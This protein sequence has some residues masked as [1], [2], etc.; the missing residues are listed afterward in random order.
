MHPQTKPSETSSTEDALAKLKQLE[1]NE[2]FNNTPQTDTPKLPKGG[3]GGFGSTYPGDNKKNINRYYIHLKLE[4]GY[5]YICKN[6]GYN[7]GFLYWPI[8]TNGKEDMEFISKEVKRISPYIWDYGTE[9][10]SV[11]TDKKN[12]YNARVR[13]AKPLSMK[14]AASLSRKLGIK[15]YITR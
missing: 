4:K 10:R 13:L 12:P 7:T 1:S 15:F 8:S 6:G 3:Y 9:W 2:N 5:R 11:R 14:R